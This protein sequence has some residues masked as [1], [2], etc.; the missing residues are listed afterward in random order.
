MTGLTVDRTTKIILVVIAAG[1][2]VNAA[3][4]VIRPAQAQNDQSSFIANEVTLIA[5]EVIA[6]ANGSCRNGKIC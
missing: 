5:T 3:G 2:W 1:L 4:N 6:I